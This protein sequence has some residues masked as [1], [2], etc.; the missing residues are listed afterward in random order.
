MSEDYPSSTINWQEDEFKEQI[1]DEA[2][3]RGFSGVSEFAR[4]VFGQVV[5]ESTSVRKEIDALEAEIDDLEE[6]IEEKQDQ[7]E[8]KREVLDYKRE[9]LAEQESVSQE[10]E[11]KLEHLAGMKQLEMQYEYNPRYKEVLQSHPDIATQEEL[12]ELIEDYVDEVD[13]QERLPQQVLEQANG[14]D[15]L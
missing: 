12:E 9:L 14:G 4:E 13:P 2:S 1:E 3:R 11:L 7:L 10:V 5:S 6:E 15:S 8:R